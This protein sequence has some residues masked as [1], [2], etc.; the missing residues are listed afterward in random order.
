M[1]HMGVSGAGRVWVLVVGCLLLPSCGKEPASHTV[2]DDSPS[3]L[4]TV[5]TGTL[6][7][8]DEPLKACDTW[9]DSL[10][11]AGCGGVELRGVDVADLPAAHRYPNGTLTTDTLRVT[12][13]YANG[14]L[15]VTEQPTP[16]SQPAP[17]PSRP[18]PGP[19]CAE[20]AGGWPFDRF[21]R[22]G[23]TR[24]NQYVT[25]AP[26]GGEAR[27]DDSQR[28]MTAPFTGDLDRHRKELAALYDGPVCVELTKASRRQLEAL[29]TRVTAEVKQRGYGF[30]GGSSGN[31]WGTVDIKVVAATEQQCR[32]LSKAHDDLVE[33]ESFLQPVDSGN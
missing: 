23:T 14:V 9:L 28:I 27:I 32:E 29:F 6:Q 11:P 30:L 25:D 20:P 21:S 12:G 33:C 24:V 17:G 15:T 1:R 18:I 2:R 19:S 8:K 22:E 26:D 10:P 5:T 7:T 4:W 31:A 3:A 13:T 16:A